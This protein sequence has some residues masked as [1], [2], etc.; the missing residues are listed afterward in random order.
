MT[1]ADLDI[2]ADGLIASESEKADIIQCIRTL[3]LTP[4]G[5]V[6]LYREF[7][8]NTTEFIGAPQGVVKNLLAVEIMDKVATFEPRASVSE[9]QTEADPDTGQ[10][11][12]KVVI[13]NG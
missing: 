13:T 5:T 7:G 4:E 6:P 1:L 12:V 11:R 9:V 8:L 3:I 10:I 2:N